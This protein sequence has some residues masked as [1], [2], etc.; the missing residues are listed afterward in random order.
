MIIEAIKGNV[1]HWW[2]CFSEYDY[3]LWIKIYML[4][5]TISV[6]FSTQCGVLII[7][8]VWKNIQFL[9]KIILE[10]RQL[11]VNVHICFALK[12]E[13]FRQ[14]ICLDD[15]FRLTNFTSIVIRGQFHRAA[16]Q[17][18]LLSR[19]CW[20]PVKLS[21]KMFINWLVVCFI[22]LRKVICLAKFST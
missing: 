16:K 3:F 13:N 4:Q 21:D 8:K 17:K 1:Q 11:F 18:N 10:N 9:Q 22:L 2:N 20:L 19:I 5:T 6:T 12:W 15:S 7:R 14:N